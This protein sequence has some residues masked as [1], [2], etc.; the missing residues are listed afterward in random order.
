MKLTIIGKNIELTEGI[1]LTVEEKLTKIKKYFNDDIDVRATV[2]A[3][4]NRQTI[5]VTI[6]PISGNIIRA[7]DSQE[8]LYAAIDVVVDKLSKQLRKYKTKLINKHHDSNSIRFENI[9]DIAD[10]Q[11]SEIKIVRR[12]KFGF[13]PMSEEE[14]ILQMELLGHNFFV[15]TNSE[16]DEMNVVY[17]RKSGDYGIIEQE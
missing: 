15:F 6:I 17:K 14:A 16:T 13:K 10:N 8:N 1:K 2:R 4:K 7:E 12:K 11:D 9:D 5:E 3:K